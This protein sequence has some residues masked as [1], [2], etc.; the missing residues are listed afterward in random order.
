MRF[1]QHFGIATDSSDDWF[2]PHLTVDTRLFLDPILILLEESQNPG[3]WAGAHD[4]LLAHFAE[5]YRRVSQASSPTSTSASVARALLTFPE[6]HEFC[7]GYT[8]KGTGGSGTGVGGANKMMDGIAVALSAGLTEPRHI[9]EIGIL[10]EGIG[11]DHISD[12]VCNILKHR[13]VDYTKS[14]AAKHGIPLE[15]HKLRSSR[16]MP[17]QGRWLSQK[18][19]LPTNPSTGGPVLLVPERFLADLPALNAD[20]WF[21]DPVNSNLRASLNLQI[22]QRASKSLIVRL[23]R[24]NPKA[25]RAWADSQVSRPDL[26]G[27]DFGDDPKGVAQWDGKTV[28]F[29]KGHPIKSVPAVTTSDELWKLLDEITKQFRLFVQNQDGWRLLWNSDGT[30][31]PEDAAQL[32]FM[33]MAQ[34]Y[35]RQFG[36]ELDREVSVGR[37][38]VDFKLSSGTSARILIEVKKVHNGKFWNGLELQLPTYLDADQC[39]HGLFVAVHYRDTKPMLQRLRD[40]PGRVRKLQRESGKT[41]R[42]L[43]VDARRKASAS[44]L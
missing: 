20:D 19:M 13:F 26:R 40:L 3:L 27:Y 34:Y 28:E 18:V 5:C 33:G 15:P 21:N 7:L 11:A 6:P 24:Q 14:V 23:A 8:A 25:L 39:T 2:D 31:K 12:A 30:Q 1:T 17:S 41:V 22:G 9:E 44:K 42:H 10:T 38:L 16:V 43:V 32:L 4:E 36:V 29:A 37:G 35:F